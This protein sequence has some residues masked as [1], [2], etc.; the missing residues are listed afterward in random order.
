MSI[1]V[2]AASGQL[3]AEVIG[4]LKQLGEP[5]IV[6]LARTPEK[7]T[8]LGVEIRPGDYTVPADLEVS[9]RGVNTLLLVSGIDAPEKRIE[10]H[11][12]VIQAAKASGVRKIVYTSIQGAESG[13]GFSPIVQSNRQT[14]RDVQAS[15]ME[16]VI[17]RN[18]VYIE[19]DVEYIDTYKKTGVIRNCAGSGRCGYTTRADLGFAYAQMLTRDSHHG[20]TYNLHG[21]PL[22]QDELANHLNRAFGTSLK[23]VPMSVEDYRKDRAAELGE[24]LGGV[25]AGIYEGISQGAVDNPSHFARAAGRPHQSWS[26]YFTQLQ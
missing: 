15:G 13:T 5:S 19:P 22:T 9:L 17:G 25:I 1:A 18:G 26:D 4:A 3:G 20:Q 16:W 14:E 21:D 11:R 12:N 24:F 23:Y 10:Q 7:A 8:G 2:T 6:G